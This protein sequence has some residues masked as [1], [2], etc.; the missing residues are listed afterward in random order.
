[1]A[2]KTAAML[3]MMVVVSLSACD[4]PIQQRTATTPT[5]PTVPTTPVTPTEPTG[6]V[7]PTGPTNPTDPSGPTGPATPSAQAQDVEAVTAQSTA[8]TAGLL[9]VPASPVPHYALVEMPAHGSVKFD[10]ANST[11][12]YTPQHDYVGADR[13]RYAVQEEGVSS[14]PATVNI[15]VLSTVPAPIPSLA[16][17]CQGLGS[18]FAPLCSF[19]AT[20]TT[21]LVQG[22]SAAAS[23]DFCGTFGGDLYSL[24]QGCFTSVDG[25]A[26]TLCKGVATAL[27]AVASQ[28]RVL[29]APADFC[30]LFSGTVI[31]DG[32]VSAYQGTPV[33]K[34]MQQQWLLG[35]TLPLSGALVPASHNSFN[36]TNA[37]IPASLSGLDPDQFFS[38]T[39]QLDMDMRGF[40]LDVHWF[41]SVKA[42]GYAPLL[43]HANTNHIGC[44]T[45]RTLEDGLREFR[46]WLDAHPDQVI[47][48]DV[49]EHLDDPVDDVSK[50]F[51]AAAA[52]IEKTLGK[53]SAKDIL[54]RPG[55]PGAAGSCTG[56]KI[57]LQLSPAQILAAGKQ[58]LIYSS[59]CGKNPGGWDAVIHDQANRRQGPSTDFGGSVYPSCVF[60]REQYKTSWTRFYD[61]ST[62]VDVV[63]NSGTAQPVTPSQIREMV[64]C[65]VD[66]PSINYLDPHTAQLRSFV[67]SWDYGQPLTNAKALCAVQNAAG[68]LQTESCV[69]LMPYACTDGSTWQVTQ[70]RGLFAD[71]QAACAAEF[72]GSRFSVPRS[73][74]ENELLKSAK[75]PGNISRVW[76]NT[77]RA[78]GAAAWTASP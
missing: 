12:T 44:T 69:Q 68:F 34:A 56:N 50:S 7:D 22:C 43:C 53:N 15:Q 18:T 78:A 4:G 55:Q 10:P 21:P 60:T 37:N 1:M 25:Q 23:V 54:L 16:S 28:C 61:S 30:A 33:H 58:V 41:P 39:Q 62:F 49:E 72:S 3:L 26:A 75:S 24:A 6:P 11:F 9:A 17:A 64:R 5:T 35:S 13:F 65:G 2:R 36:Y 67:W 42:G 73:G 74:Y 48:L 45:E 47:V 76:L 71:G 14:T 31:A 40:E 66:M 63:T 70:A 27:Q 20:A 19:I 38:F 46:A 8:V 52:M 51:P 57:P 59:G 29:Y 32:A 77:T